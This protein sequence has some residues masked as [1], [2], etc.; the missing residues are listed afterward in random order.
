[1]KV[2]VVS[3]LLVGLVGSGLQLG[4]AERVTLIFCVVLVLFAEIL[5]SALEALVDLHT[6]EF[7]DR[8]K[9]TKDA[10]AAGVLVLA[11]GTVA[12][13]AAVLVSNWRAVV[14][15]GPAIARQVAA[16]LPLAAA[17]ALLI[18]DRRRAAWVDVFLVL[19]GGGL[20]VLLA[21]WTTSTVFSAMTAGL[22]GACV[23]VA[24]RRR[25]GR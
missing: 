18:A 12:I 17:A 3:G 22:F 1:M 9:V 6:D 13:F 14:E 23:A 19:A 5:N 10:A 20:V 11:I 16:G 7:H 15:A 25:R 21:T 4:L 2:H 24:V 8:A